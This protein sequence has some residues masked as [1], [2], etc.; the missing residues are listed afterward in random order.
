MCDFVAL[1]RYLAKVSPPDLFHIEYARVHENTAWDS[2]WLQFIADYGPRHRIIAQLIGCELP[3]FAKAVDT[4]KTLPIAGIDLNLGCPVPKVFKKNVG[5]GLLRDLETVNAVVGTLRQAIPAPLTFSVK[6]RLGFNQ[7]DA[8]QGVMEIL[9]KHSV[10]W[11]TV[12]L[13]TVADGYHAPA[14]F[15][16]AKEVAAAAP[17]PILLNGDIQTVDQGLALIKETGAWGVSIGRGAIRYPWIFAKARAQ[18]EALLNPSPSVVEGVG[19]G[20]VSAY[21]PATYADAHDYLCWTVANCHS[22]GPMKGYLNFL[23]L[24]VD[25]QGRFLKAMRQS[26]TPADLLKLGEEWLLP[27]ADEVFPE[28]P[29]PRL[30]ARPS[31]ERPRANPADATE[32]ACGDGV[33]D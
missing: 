10:D 23:G 29:F 11:C 6:F 5:G 3:Y 12:H 21:R 18:R 7:P 26:R 16:L 2:E 22:I 33:C 28:A 17:C 8:W 24:S 30:Y 20:P 4:L 32:S 14:Q 27:R 15:H 13:R 25:E 1:G 31:M 19:G 9:R